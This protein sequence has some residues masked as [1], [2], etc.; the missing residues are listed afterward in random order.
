M[1]SPAALA[2][3]PQTSGGITG[4][5]AKGQ[6]ERLIRVAQMLLIESGYPMGARRVNRLARD[7]E[8]RVAGNGWSFF[9]YFANRIQLDAQKRRELL[10]RPDIAR[11]IAYADPTGETAV[12]NVM[13]G[14]R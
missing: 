3:A 10:S 9:D 14:A 6:T 4:A 7:F 2:A 11:V 5:E 1:R 12:N 13:K 8:S